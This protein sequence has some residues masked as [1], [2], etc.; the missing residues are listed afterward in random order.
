MGERMGEVESRNGVGGLS[1]THTGHQVQ[2][3]LLVP[4]AAL[5]DISKVGGDVARTDNT[6]INCIQSQRKPS[7][8]TPY[9]AGQMERLETRAMSTEKKRIPT[10]LLTW[11][12]RCPRPI[13]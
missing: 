3:A 6:N 2:Q 4:V 10:A 7:R 5:Q 9:L 1:P 11:T 12:V 8:A 13:T